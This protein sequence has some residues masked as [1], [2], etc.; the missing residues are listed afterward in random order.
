MT[1]GF[2]Q[3]GIGSQLVWLGF[4][5]A[6]EAGGQ[7]LESRHFDELPDPPIGEDDG[8][9]PLEKEVVELLVRG[10]KELKRWGD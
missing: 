10:E 8:E 6:F 1:V 2:E 5:D 9:S 4:Q 3:L 7:F